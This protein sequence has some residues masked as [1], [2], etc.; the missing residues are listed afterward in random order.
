MKMTTKQGVIPAAAALMVLAGGAQGAISFAAGST[1]S[2]PQRP[3]GVVIAD[4]NGDGRA[5]VA[6]ATD[7]QDKIT[8]H[9]GNG[10]GGFGGP[11][12]SLTGSGSGPDTMVALDWDNDGDM[13][14]AVV[15]KNFNQLAIFANTGGGTFVPAGVTAAVG[16]NA[17]GLIHADVN[18][19]GVRDFATANRD[20]N[21]VSLVIRNG[22]SLSTLSLGTGVE[23]RA[24]SVGDIT[25]DGIADLAVSC[26]RDRTVQTFRGVGGGAFALAQTLF[27]NPTTRPDGLVLTDLSGDG[28]VDIAVAVSDNDIPLNQVSVFRNLGGTFGG[29]TSFNTGGTNHSTVVAADFDRDGNMDIAV[30]NEDSGSVSLM[31][32]LGTG[33]LGAAIV[34]GTGA[35]PDSI[36]VGDL[37]GDT[38]ADLAVSNRDSNTTVT[39]RN[40]AVPPPPPCDPDFNQDG[41][42]NQDDVAYLVNVIAGGA[43]PSGRNPDFNNDGNV[44]Q[45]DYI[46]LVNVVAGGVCP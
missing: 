40:T 24:V 8:V 25:G 36:A 16:S 35:H 44:D 10:A 18:G 21:S 32:G 5:D 33:A 42:A 12:S 1:L 20:S 37:N 29:F 22:M 3:A 19:D 26:H 2:T 41:N 27:V 6:T 23:P 17:R 11:V 46:S 39:L 34:M 45:D 9:F 30:A 28:R 14:I 13:D 38:L 31:P 43:N 15:L 4:F 7:T